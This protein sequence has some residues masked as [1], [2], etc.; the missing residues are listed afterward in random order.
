MKLLAMTSLNVW[1]LTIPLGT[2]CN[3]AVK[4]LNEPQRHTSGAHTLLPSSLWV[5]GVLSQN[6]GHLI[7]HRT[8]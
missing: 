8:P 1:C 7:V 5:Q 2:A 3:K 6:E 4:S